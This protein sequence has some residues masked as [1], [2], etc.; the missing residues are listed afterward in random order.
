[1]NKYIAGLTNV[2]I[3]LIS[4][5]LIGGICYLKHSEIPPVLPFDVLTPVIIILI[6]L[7]IVFSLYQINKHRSEKKGNQ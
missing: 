6:I 3:L 1:M 5:I 4:L 2:G 7:S